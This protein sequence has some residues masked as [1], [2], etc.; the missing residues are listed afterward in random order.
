MQISI[1]NKVI[2]LFHGAKLK[3]GLLKFN[4][5]YFRAVMDGKATLLDQY[6]NLV[7]INGAAEDG[8]SYTVVTVKE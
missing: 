4:E 5:D 3:H 1:N 6:G 8:V 2:E 7:E